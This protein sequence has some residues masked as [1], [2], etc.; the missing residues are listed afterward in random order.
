MS[1]LIFLFFLLQIV[2]LIPIKDRRS[3]K[4]DFPWMT[5]TLVG[6]NVFI[7]VVVTLLIYR[8]PGSTDEAFW[9]LLYPYMEVPD[10]VMQRQ[11][12]GAL[13]ALSSGFLHGGWG[14]LLGNMFVLW[15]FGRKV[16]D[17]T[18]PV[19]FG[20]FYLACLF[21]ASLTSVLARYTLSA[22]NA[23]MPSLGASGAISGLMAAYL[24]LYSGEKVLTFIFPIPIPFWL[25]AWIFIVQ[26]IMTDAVTGQLIQEI[27]QRVAN[28]SLGVNVFAH[29]GGTLGGLILIYFF[30]HPE[31][32]AQRR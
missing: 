11:G 21:A 29:M 5:L 23:Q 1:L 7:H 25:P 9:N 16:E 26:K 12:L 30:L 27:S 2:T 32:L 22:F 13:S 15:F 6:L 8:Q 24:F 18:G 3:R 14:H 17:A 10:L 28:F 4:R 31:V 19:R 20:L